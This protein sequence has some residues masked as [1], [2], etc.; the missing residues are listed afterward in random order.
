MNTLYD[1]LRPGGTLLRRFE[2]Q[3]ISL[4]NSK[5][6]FAKLIRDSG[7]TNEL[8]SWNVDRVVRKESKAF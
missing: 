2:W 8:R 7:C 3:S 6:I 4:S 1:E 5:V